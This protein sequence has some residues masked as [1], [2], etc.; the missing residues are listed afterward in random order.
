M[1]FVFPFKKHW[2]RRG[3]AKENGQSCVRRVTYDR[4]A[5]CT[6]VALTLSGKIYKR[7][8]EGA[9]RSD[10][11]LET[12]KHLQRH[13]HGPIILI[14]GRACI[15]TSKQVQGYLS[16]HPEIHVDYYQLTHLNSIQKNIVTA[17]SNHTSEML[18]PLIKTKSA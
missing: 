6:V 18:D 10:Q 17:T 7:H 4:R 13:I 9:I 2:L 16:E 12:L 14:W 5:L 1:N 3:H 11:V 15:H 8:F